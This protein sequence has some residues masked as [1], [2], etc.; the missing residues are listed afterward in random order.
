MV[1]VRELGLGLGLAISWL[2]RGKEKGIY[3]YCV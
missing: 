2:C 1:K 3:F